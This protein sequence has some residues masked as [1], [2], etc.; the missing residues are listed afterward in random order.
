MIVAK[1]FI[2]SVREAL[3]DLDLRQADLAEMLGIS[4]ATVSQRLS[5]DSI[6]SSTMDRYAEALDIEFELTWRLKGERKRTR[7]KASVAS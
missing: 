7:S 5:A 4:A 6:S 2:E 1:Q 3:D